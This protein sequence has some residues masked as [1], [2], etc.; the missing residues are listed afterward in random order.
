MDL[1]RLKTT[2]S[3][4]YGVPWSTTPHSAHLRTSHSTQP[5]GP[6]PQ[7]PKPPPAPLG[8]A[9]EELGDSTGARGPCSGR[10][11]PTPVPPRRGGPCA[12]PPVG[13]PG[14]AVRLGCGS[15]RAPITLC[16]CPWLLGGGGGG[17]MCEEPATSRVTAC[18]CSSGGLRQP[19]C[20]DRSALASRSRRLR[21]FRLL[22]L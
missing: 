14:G 12:T 21:R 20:W 17:G 19:G 2:K 15:L 11:D 16:C 8:G 22:R 5:L 7:A 1:R 13:G 6:A 9:E 10:P 18:C 3:E 4:E